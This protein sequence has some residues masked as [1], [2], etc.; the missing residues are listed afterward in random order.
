MLKWLR[1]VAG[2][3]IGLIVIY[4]LY[5]I[6]NGRSQV[7]SKVTTYFLGAQEIEAFY[8]GFS[9]VALIEFY[10]KTG[11]DL[12]D[13]RNASAELVK[14]ID[15]VCYRFYEVGIGYPV[16]GEAL[17]PPDTIPDPKIL[18]V[19]V[20]D[21]WTFGG[22]KTPYHCDRIDTS[23]QERAE[24]LKTQMQ[25][26]QQWPLQVKH[27]KTIVA[28]LRERQPDTSAIHIA[29]RGEALANGIGFGGS[30][31]GNLK[32]TFATVGTFQESKRIF[33]FFEVSKGFYVRKDITEA[34]YG[35]QLS[36]LE[37][38][39]SVLGLGPAKATLTFAEPE[40]IAV[41][42]YIDLL[43]ASEKFDYDI[44]KNPKTIDAYM[45]E[46]VEQQLKTIHDKSVE[47]SKRLTQLFIRKYGL[48]ADIE[49]S[50]KFT[51][52]EQSSPQLSGAS[53]AAATTKNVEKASSK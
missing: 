27:A 1:W 40:L 34:T 53:S 21:S 2:V 13:M 22:K 7:Q 3:V 37:V 38:E 46:D 49:T 5:R 15:G 10:D 23:P 45:R 52:K 6:I 12:G 26:D 33:F 50:I 25:A 17:Q 35:S 29:A 30:Y 44:K 18:S 11:N 43:V 14:K 36:G 42:R 51:V 24:K 16:L 4:G 19:N 20:T 28:L 8:T 47:Q 9:W 32:V 31:L 39:T 48:E 41:N